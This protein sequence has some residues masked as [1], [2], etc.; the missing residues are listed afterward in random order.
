MQYLISPNGQYVGVLIGTASEVIDQIPEDHT[1]TALPPPRPTD[2]WNGTEWVATGTAPTP[3]HKFDYATKQW[4]DSRTLDEAKKQKWEAIKL[5]RNKLEFGGFMYLGKKFDSDQISQVR[6]IAAVMLAQ[7]ITWT[8]ADDSSIELDGE[9]LTG[10]GASLAN[11]VKN[12]HT[13]GR[14]ARQLIEQAQ[15][16]ED[17]EAVIL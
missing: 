15:T 11:H 10:L 13:R 1:T 16:H 8:L 6:I 4:K 12:S 9:Q 5:Q 3:Y 7:P 17:V 2:Y 14:L